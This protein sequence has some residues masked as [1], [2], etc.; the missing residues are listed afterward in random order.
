MYR[1]VI[2]NCLIKK[3]AVICNH[4]PGG[5]MSKKRLLKR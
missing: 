4:F 5:Q 1:V 2:D 3:E